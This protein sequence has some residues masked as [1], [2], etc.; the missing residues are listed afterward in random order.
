MIIGFDAKRA[1]QNQTGLGG[2]SRFVLQNL[3]KYYPNNKYLLFAPKQG[4]LFRPQE[5]CFETVLAPQKTALGQSLWRSF[6]INNHLEQSKLDVFHGL[7]NELP[8]N[9]HRLK[10][11]KVV[12]IHD[13][14][15][16]RYPQQYPFFDRQ[17]YLQKT[18]RALASAD[19]I[20]VPSNQTASDLVNLLQAD[21][22]KI[23]TIHQ[24]CHPAFN[25]KQPQSTFRNL[26][27][28][29]GIKQ[30]Y[31][32]SVGRFETRKNQ[33][34]IVEAFAS[35]SRQNL[36]LVLVGQMNK[37]GKKLQTLAINKNLPITFIDKIQVT[38]LAALYQHAYAVVYPSVYEGF[39]I[40]LVE[41]FAAKV[42]IISS[43]ASCLPEI[44]GQA[45]LYIKPLDTHALSIAMQSLIDDSKLYQYH[46]QESALAYARFEPKLLIEALYNQVYST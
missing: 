41:A 20:V 32:L 30:P 15:F 33:T 19:K 29:F 11:K 16:L 17:I 28:R 39:G 7:S 37:L 44:G 8:W 38:E 1:F 5:D 4:S 36:Q 34:G 43:N 24:A 45:P 10:V 13:V 26:A 6:G 25:Q 27:N 21:S 31:F 42:P 12:T 18:K 35:L 9:I 22:A 46:K 14:I 40:P 23:T 2:Y 3:A